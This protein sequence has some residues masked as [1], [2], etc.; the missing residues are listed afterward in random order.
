MENVLS[1]RAAL[2]MLTA[3]VAIAAASRGSAAELPM[4]TVRKDPS[5]DCCTG[6]PIMC[7]RRAS[8]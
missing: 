1:R 6:W 7:V 4:V 3:A 5:C 2:R 8:Q